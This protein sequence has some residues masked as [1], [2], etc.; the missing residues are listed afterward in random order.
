MLD[1]GR[2]GES[3]QILWHRL[4]FGRCDLGRQGGGTPVSSPPDGFSMPIEM[5][6]GACSGV[7]LADQPGA[8]VACPHCGGHLQVP[9]FASE[10]GISEQTPVEAPA[11]DQPGSV[12]SVTFAPSMP[13]LS[14]SSYTND[15]STDLLPDQQP[16]PMEPPTEAIP[17]AE[18][19]RRL[20][21]AAASTLSDQVP[22]PYPT[23][24]RRH[25]WSRRPGSTVRRSR[26][27]R[28]CLPIAP[29]CQTLRT[30]ENW[31]KPPRSSHWARH[32]LRNPLLRQWRNPLRRITK[33][34]PPGRAG[35]PRPEVAV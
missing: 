28:R 9:H 35:S 23:R 32:R 26:R 33:T 13:T 3:A 24:G 31:R 15:P 4:D 1:R 2:L 34:Q 12:P 8:I 19:A 10:G 30:L 20:A 18:T 17:Q 14:P 11:A 6:C 21:E 5:Q 29:Y 27:C 22:R 16:K 7:F 25:G